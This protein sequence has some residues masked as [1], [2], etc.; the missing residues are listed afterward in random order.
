MFFVRGLLGGHVVSVT[1][2]NDNKGMSWY[3][4]ELLNMA[5][6]IADRLLVAFN[7]STGIPYSRVG[8][9]LE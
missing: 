5:I 1:L 4:G 9:I 8:T 2:K 6:D 3:D 7:T